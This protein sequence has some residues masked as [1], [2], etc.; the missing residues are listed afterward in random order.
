MITA[1][2]SPPLVMSSNSVSEE[3]TLSSLIQA[4]RVM[5]LY[6]S[7]DDVLLTG[8]VWAEALASFSLFAFREDSRAMGAVG[9]SHA[10]TLASDVQR[11][12]VHDIDV[13][14][15][16]PTHSVH[17]YLASAL[18]RQILLDAVTNQYPI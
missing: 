3:A 18:F 10:E 5:N 16:V 9:I 6:S 15:Q 13:S 12:F 8:F 11:G 17:A 2:N 14:T 4:S 7:N 1:A